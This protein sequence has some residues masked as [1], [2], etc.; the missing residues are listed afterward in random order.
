M[1]KFGFYSLL[2]IVASAVISGCG[3]GGSTTKQISG[4]VLD[5]K[6]AEPISGAKLTTGTNSATSGSDGSYTL[7]VSGSGTAIVKAEK[8]GY[9]QNVKAV[10]VNSS[11]TQTTLNIDMLKVAY[12]KTVAA[13]SDFTVTVPGSTGSVDIHAGSLVQDDGSAPQ[14]QIVANLTPIN[15]AQDIHMMPG[16]MT[17]DNDKPI[18]SFGAMMVEFKDTAG[19]KLQLASGESATIRIPVSNKGSS[20]YLPATIPLYYM[21]ETTGKWKKYGTDAT[22]NSAK[23]YYE[24]TVSHFSPPNADRPYT[25]ININGCVEDANGTKVPNADIEMVGFD[26]N[27]ILTTTTDSNGKFTVM[28]RS[29]STSLVTASTESML[30]NTEKVINPTADYTIPDCLVMGE[31]PLTVRLTW[32]ES[33]SD[34]DTHVFGPNNFHIWWTHK[35]TYANDHAE[36]DVDDTDSYG[37][38]VFTARNLPE[39]TY[40]YCVRHYA[41]SSDITHSGAR[42]ELKVNSTRRVFVPPTAPAQGASDDWWNVF[43]FVV[44]S[45]G[46]IT[47]TIVNTWSTKAPDGTDAYKVAKTIN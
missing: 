40:H 37:P 12:S 3:G 13:G 41:G 10:T 7:N 36:L 5:F 43:D 28:A 35:G 26:Y 44:D 42:V 34:L 6:T 39:G 29:G 32:G 18:E 19:H 4:K 27:S 20:S 30:S 47:I 23:T 38:E 22:L 31:I 15:P 25:T 14:G 8:D 2:A 17:D 21:D 45:N 11:N 24:G 1:K 46:N 33:P 16:I 9:A